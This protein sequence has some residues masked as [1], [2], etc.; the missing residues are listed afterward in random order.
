VH[1]SWG[2]ER[3]ETVSVLSV[4]AAVGKF[5]RPDLVREAGFGLTLVYRF[6]MPIACRVATSGRDKR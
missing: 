6:V 2:S 5:A 1:A 4:A 3:R